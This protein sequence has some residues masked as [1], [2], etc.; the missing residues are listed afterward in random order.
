M[1]VPYGAQTAAVPSDS[2][3]HTQPDAP[4]AAKPDMPAAEAALPLDS[5]ADVPVNTEGEPEAVAPQAHDVGAIGPGV[6]ALAAVPP[7]LTIADAIRVTVSPVAERDGLSIHPDA[8]ARMPLVVAVLAA[9]EVMAPLSPD[10]DTR[11]NEPSRSPLAAAGRTPTVVV[12]I[13]MWK[14]GETD[15]G[16]EDE[17][18]KAR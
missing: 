11:S 2:A 7:L 5:A 4:P 13:A 12:T 3:E 14:T 6:T 1:V 10:A 16:H 15:D 9:S 8:S 17:L 18:D